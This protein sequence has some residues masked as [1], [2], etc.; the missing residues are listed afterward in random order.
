MFDSKTKLGKAAIEWKGQS[1][2]VST[3]FDDPYYSMGGG[4]EETRHVFL[5]GNRLAERWPPG[6]D[7]V[8]AELGFGTGLN[9][10]ETTRQWISLGSPN[11]VLKYYSF[12]Q[13]PMTKKE[14]ERSLAVWDELSELSGPLVDRWSSIDQLVE[15]AIKN[16]DLTVYFGDANDVLPT[17]ELN[18][19]AWYLDGFSPAKNPELW[20]KDL[21]KAV[22]SNTSDKG[23]IA[24]YTAAGWVRRNLSEAGF[25]VSKV[26]GYGRKRDM[27]V[28]TKSIGP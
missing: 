24:T 12:E 2:P 4:L 19:N 5:R 13:Y 23:T 16:V 21:M 9:F 14:I 26:P 15:I 1:V 8:I 3:Q 28:A 7:F 27:T 11:H 25:L 17:M 6:E 10:L 20:Q 18:A 22:Y